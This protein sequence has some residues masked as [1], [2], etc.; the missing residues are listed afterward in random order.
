MVFGGV[1]ASDLDLIGVTG[2]RAWVPSLTG[3]GVMVAQPEAQES[4]TAWEVGPVT[5][6]Q[7]ASLFTWVSASG[8][9]TSFPNAL[10]Q[11]SSHASLVGGFFYGRTNGVA[12]SIS[13]V[14][15]YEASN[16]V[17]GLVVPEISIPGRVVNQ[18][19][20][21]GMQH[22]GVDQEYD[23]YAARY[24]TLFVSGI[25]NSGAVNS[26]G[27]AYNG[28]G[29]GAFGGSSAI[30]PT[31]DGRSKPDITA[32][33]TAPYIQ[34]SFSTPLVA[35]VAAILIQAGARSDGGAGTASDAIDLRTVKA[36]LLNGAE[37]PDGWTN[38]PTR[39]LD[40]RYGAGILD[41][42]NAYRQLLG[43]KHGPTAS[44]SNLVES[45][46]PPLAATNPIATRRGWNLGTV[47]SSV[48]WDGVHHY[49]FDLAPATNRTFNF[50]ATLV[51]LRQRTKSAINDLDLFLYNSDDSTVVA[52][53]LS[54]VDNVE[55][56][57]ATNLPSGRY[58]LQVLKKGSATKVVTADETY[59]LVF[60]FGPV[61]AP[62]LLNLAEEAGQFR[63]RLV[64]EPAQSYVVEATT[65]LCNWESVVTNRTS[66]LGFFDFTHVTASTNCVYRA[67]EAP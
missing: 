59:A 39:P 27:T 13:H 52:S 34:T 25:G 54:A 50:V 56:V 5:V 14:H 55:H 16:F 44:T 45:A 35:G 9:A 61:E 66:A 40:A 67:R 8:S 65:D 31:S 49:G 21:F 53:S 7:P 10:G 11:E 38:G 41:I 48:A 3:S 26:P 17:S 47:S 19:F 28:L 2:L 63:A 42:L 51:W 43:G 6:S 20:V 46:H 36:L 57:F 23:D 15:N 1:E 30:G 4:P 64:G 12:P 62:R 24:G 18:S 37:K 60:D 29:V 22:S 58:D 33:I 32:P